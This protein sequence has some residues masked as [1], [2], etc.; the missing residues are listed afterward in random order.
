MKIT[1]IGT[2]Y[3]GLTSAVC[4]A[5][6]GHDV[7]C[8]D[9][10]ERKIES[11]NNKIPTIY[12]E[13]LQE[14]LA[15]LV[16][17]GN[18]KFTTDTQYGITNSQVILLAVGTPQGENTGEANLQYIFE[19]SK[20]CAEFVSEYKLFI[21]KSTVPVGTNHKIKQI[22]EGEANIEIDV[23]SNPEFMRE[24]FAIAD[25]N[26]PDRIVL[27]VE[28]SRAKKLT[29][30]LYQTWVDAD[31]PIVFTDIKTAELIKYASNSFLMAKVAFINEI[32]S[33]CRKLNCNIQD[34]S[35][36]MG[37]DNRIGKAFLNPGPGI[38]GSCFPKD[39]NALSHIASKNGVNL[40]ILNQ[41]IES[42]KLRFIEMADLI[43]SLVKSSHTKQLSILGLAF[44]AGTDD[45]RTSPAIEIIKYLLADNFHIHAYDPQA[46][47]NAKLVLQDSINYCE[48]TKDC[49]N[50]CENIVILTEWQEFKEITKFD[51]FAH[52]NVIDLRGIL[53]TI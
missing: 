34:V 27:G 24:G 50:K 22:I 46:I 23:A 51:D 5:D 33:L 35:K 11:L 32:E 13:G 7:I 39:G 53:P 31:Y 29:T 49:F 38:G 9:K 36:S 48:S 25:F 12:E 2:G 8:V 42:N 10:D 47:A 41:V 30:E 43:K 20:E 40:S 16:D 21:T 18:I 17:F 44:K 28:T 26:E 6:R 15:K 37:L 19:A 14:L 1:I 52:K 45:V 3:V 4:F